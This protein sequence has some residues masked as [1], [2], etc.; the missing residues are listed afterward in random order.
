MRLN[1]G[2]AVGGT[3]DIF[4]NNITEIIQEIVNR[5]G[6][7]S[8]NAMGLR[9]DDNGSPGY[10]DFRSMNHWGSPKGALLVITYREGSASSPTDT[11]P[12]YTSGHQP[13]KGAV[14]VSTSSA[15]SFHVMDAGSGVEFSSIVLSIDGNGVIPSITGSS[16]DY[17]VSYQPDGGFTPGSQGSVRI[18]AADR[19]GN[20]MSDDTYTITFASPSPTDTTPPYTSGHQPAKGATGV[21]KSSSVSLHVRD[22][23]SGVDS[24]SIV[25]TVDGQAV[26]PT[27]TGNS[28]DYTITY[29]PES[30]FSSEQVVNVTVQASDL[31]DNSMVVETYSFTVESSG[32]GGETHTI[33][34]TTAAS[35]D[36]GYSFDDK[37]PIFHYSNL[38]VGLQWESTFRIG[39]RFPNVSIP[40]GATIESASLT[41]YTFVSH[42][43]GS[44]PYNLNM[45]IR[46]LDTDNVGGFTSSYN[47]DTLP[48]TTAMEYWD[49]NMRLNDGV[50]VGGTDDIFPNDITE[51]IQEIVN[52]AGWSSGNAMGLR[53][54]D[55][56]SPAYSNFRSMDHW[57]SP[58]GA[59]LSV[60]Y[61]VN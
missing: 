4:P 5:A 2:V 23:G 61:R 31:E 27:I 54:D 24:S 32:G 3:D 36:D 46:G 33:T 59:L 50:A 52:R 29:T 39:L 44:L 21:S 60:V 57:G 35:Y 47:W 17:A 51:I 16:S 37:A 40:A 9:I 22:D 42:P 30:S 25:L 56:G 45:I 26:T 1:D 10:S 8:G 20:I 6:W 14:D 43:D 19:D 13:A 11:T 48:L 12:P 7:S 49:I 53:I 58:K 38:R 55:N 28:S 15:L 41:L 34:A 18:E